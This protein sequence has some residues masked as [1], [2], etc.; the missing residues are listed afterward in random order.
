MIDQHPTAV[1]RSAP[2]GAQ[3]PVIRRLKA[4][5]AALRTALYLGRELSDRTLR[6]LGRHVER[7]RADLASTAPDAA[8]AGLETLRAIREVHDQL[9]LRLTHQRDEAA[10]GLRHLRTGKRTLRAYSESL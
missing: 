9:A 3:P 10:A 4:I 6:D 7:L 2:A 8:R 5:E 1:L